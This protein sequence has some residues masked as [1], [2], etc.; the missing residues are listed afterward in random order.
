[1]KEKLIQLFHNFLPKTSIH[2]LRIN[3]NNF[4]FTFIYEENND[5]KSF[6][7]FVEYNHDLRKHFISFYYPYI[8]VWTQKNLQSINSIELSPKEYENLKN[9]F[10]DHFNNQINNFLPKI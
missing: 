9:M 8:D 2:N 3:E 4:S 7:L 10:V 6:E 1:M 5:V